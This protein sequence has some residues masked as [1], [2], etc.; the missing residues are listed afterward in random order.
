MNDKQLSSFI[1]VAESGSFSAAARKQFI[2]PQAILQQVD[3]L[4]REVGV[5]L[6]HRTHRGVKLTSAGKMFYCGSLDLLKQME[7]LLHAVRSHASKQEQELTIGVFATKLM[8][9]LCIGF[10][11]KF[12]SL[13][14][15]YVLISDSSWLTSLNLVSDG[16]LDVFEHAEVPE[17][18]QEGLLFTPLFRCKC[19]CIVSP[20]HPLASHKMLVPSDLSRM[21]ICVFG[22]SCLP[23]IRSYLQKAAPGASLIDDQS[24]VPFVFN[25]CS[26]GGVCIIAEI[27]AEEYYP[28]HAIP[29]ECN[30][31][32]TFGIVCKENPSAT[33]RQFLDYAKQ[34]YSQ[35]I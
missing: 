1:S 26:N 32:Y 30:L 11:S 10:S 15:K 16:T 21:K 34:E 24:G 17:V 29:F 13:P 18:Y 14:L 27:F 7:N 35:T 33:V 12:P 8:N 23:G 19:V 22:E 6:L 20:T 31:Q 5:Q 4:E 3:L 9:Q 25:H 28:L 2:S